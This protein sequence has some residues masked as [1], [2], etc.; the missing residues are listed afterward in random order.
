[1]VDRANRTWSEFSYFVVDAGGQLEIRWF[2]EEP[3]TQL[4]GGVSLIMRPKK[5]FDRDYTRE[6]WQLDE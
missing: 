5:I 2:E 6:L 4:L 3:Q 1:M